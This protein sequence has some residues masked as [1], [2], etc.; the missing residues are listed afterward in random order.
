VDV[1][2]ELLQP[3]EPLLVGY[4]LPWRKSHPGKDAVIFFFDRQIETVLH[5]TTQKRD[6]NFH[7]MSII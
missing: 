4:Y 3:S 2:L 5:V 7:H 6:L 1:Q